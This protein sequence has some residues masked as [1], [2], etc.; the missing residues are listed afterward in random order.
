MLKTFP[1]YLADMLAVLVL[2]HPSKGIKEW[3]GCLQIQ[4][5][6]IDNHSVLNIYKGFWRGITISNLYSV[7]AP[8]K[9]YEANS[10]HQANYSKLF[11]DDF[12][13][14]RRDIR[15]FLPSWA[16]TV[17]LTEE[18]SDNEDNDAANGS[19]AEGG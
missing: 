3:I 1:N 8:P 18:L 9:L 4:W 13:R 14:C 15:P 7:F 16:H 6:M 19:A 17:R 5:M 2:K 11:G 10:P 12:S